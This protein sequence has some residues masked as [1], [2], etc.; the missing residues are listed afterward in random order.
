MKHKF[1]FSIAAFLAVLLVVAA[2]FGMDKKPDLNDVTHTLAFVFTQSGVVSACAGT[3]VGP[4]V[5]LTADHCWQIHAPGK[6]ER[7]QFVSIDGAKALPI[8]SNA[9]DGAD[10]VLLE[11]K[12]GFK[13][14]VTPAPRVLITGEELSFYGY[15]QHL[16]KLFRRGYVMGSVTD[17]DG[18]YAALDANTFFGDSGSG[19]FDSAGNLV[20]VVNDIY[21]SDP[22]DGYV[23]HYVVLL[24][25]KFTAQA[26]KEATQK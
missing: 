2:S 20:A 16:A 25:L 21:I 13:Q 9:P 26:Y 1:V 6:D 5:L 23:F 19:V 22:K 8:V 11:V 15:P 24:P 18:E 14:W 7:A 4:N 17:D 10:H 12:A 3:A